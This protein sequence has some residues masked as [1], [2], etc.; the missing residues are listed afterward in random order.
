MEK[1]IL[2]TLI[3]ALALVLYGCTST[4]D[5]GNGAQAPPAEQGAYGGAQAG[6]GAQPASDNG[7]AAGASGQ[8]NGANGAQNGAAGGQFA[9]SGMFAND[10]AFG[11]VDLSNVSQA[12]Q[13]PTAGQIGRAHV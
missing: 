12:D 5:N 1:L 11:G 13:D 2:A 8:G 3:V 10:T 7:Q 4:A 6:N 9:N